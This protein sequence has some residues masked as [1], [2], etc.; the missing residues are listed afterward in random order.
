MVSKLRLGMFASVLIATAA[1]CL[2]QEVSE[3]DINRLV[4]VYWTQR[5]AGLDLNE[6]L[7]YKLSGR[8]RI[9]FVHVILSAAKNLFPR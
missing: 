5:V 7:S 9:A 6:T 2:G 4:G 8:P 3:R 1:A